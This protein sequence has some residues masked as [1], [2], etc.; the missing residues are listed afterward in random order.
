ML[1]APT[2][3]VLV[4]SQVR[5]V[6]SDTVHVATLSQTAYSHLY[7]PDVASESLKST[8]KFEVWYELAGES[9]E[10]DGSVLS[11]FNVDDCIGSP[12]SSRYLTY[13]VP[14]VVHDIVVIGGS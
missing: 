4:P 12:S 2:V 11:S 6:P 9:I 8:T 14:S 7:N 1:D 13:C 5:D 3:I 10:L